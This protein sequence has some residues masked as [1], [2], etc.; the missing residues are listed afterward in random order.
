MKSFRVS[1]SWDQVFAMASG[2]FMVGVRFLGLGL[3]GLGFPGFRVSEFSLRLH[4]VPV[5]WVQG[6]WDWVC[7][8]RVSEFRVDGWVHRSIDVLGFGWVRGFWCL[9]FRI[10]GFQGLGLG[11][12]NQKFMR[13]SSR[14]KLDELRSHSLA[15]LGF[16]GS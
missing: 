6:V 11:S 4:A 9:S 7:G 10:L 1:G 16:L 15:V 12:S 14:L 13:N 8:F 5:F 2:C 3:P